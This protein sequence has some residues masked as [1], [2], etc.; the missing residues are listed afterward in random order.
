MPRLKMLRGPEPGREIPLGEDLMT[1]GR[2]RKNDIII[3]DNEV[4]RVHC[5]LVRVLDD[6]EIHDLGSTNGTFV[7]GQ[8]IDEGGWLLSGR[9]IVELGDSITLEYL[10]TDIRTGTAPPMPA[11]ATDLNVT[12]YY[13]VIQ[14]LSVNQPEIYILDRL[15]ISLG[16]DLDND[17]VLQEPEVSRHHLRMVLTQDGYTI[18]DL[19]T[20]NG[21]LLNSNALVQQQLLRVGDHINIGENLIMW[22][23]DQP[24]AVLAKLDDTGEQ[25]VSEEEETD[26]D[27]DAQTHGMRTKMNVRSQVEAALDQTHMS[28]GHGLEPNELTKSVFIAYA[29]EDWRGLVGRL[30]ISLEDSGIKVFSEQYLTPNTDGWEKAIEQAT[31]E[32]ACLLAIISESSL[33]VPYVQK[34]IRHFVSREKPILL[35]QYGRVSKLPIMIQNMPAIQFDR[36]RPEKTLSMILAELKRLGLGS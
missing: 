5:R 25:P 30:H 16:R 20:M 17:I 18:E 22:Y 13:L 7:N 34:A 19:N 2:G 9:S 36:V 26:T 15:T 28:L 4:S 32:S 31:T 14:Q 29:R 12:T 23:T 1:I 6:Y 33:E 3:Q 21:S 27:G 24:E 8:K 10:P 11:V 35:V